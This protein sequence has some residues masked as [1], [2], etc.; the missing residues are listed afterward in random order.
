[1]NVN[2][3]YTGNMFENKRHGKGTFTW[4]KGEKQ[5]SDYDYF[6]Y[7][8]TWKDDALHG[9]GIFV[10]NENYKYTGSWKE[11]KMH[12]FGQEEIYVNENSKYD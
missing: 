11:G 12:G 2:G 10:K 5:D 4:T 3:V 1:M 7:H 9:E 6:Y 8:G